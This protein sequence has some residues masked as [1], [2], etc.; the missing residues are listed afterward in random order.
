MNSAPI[1]PLISER[2]RTNVRRMT[3]AP[4]FA[5]YSHMESTFLQ[6]RCVAQFKNSAAEFRANNSNSLA[7]AEI[8][9]TSSRMSH[10][11]G[12]PEVIGARLK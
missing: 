8:R 4:R 10:L 12:R 7:R 5:E 2:G 6:P 3:A 9:C 1:K 11:R